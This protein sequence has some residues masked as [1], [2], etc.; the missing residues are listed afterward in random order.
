MVKTLILTLPD[1]GAQVQAHPAVHIH[2]F[3]SPV[4]LEVLR[5]ETKSS[6]WGKGLRREA[7][8]AKR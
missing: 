5:E 2:L 3:L 6:E 1:L 8:T 4:L 7:A